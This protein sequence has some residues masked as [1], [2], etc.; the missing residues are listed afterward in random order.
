MDENKASEERQS[1]WKTNIGW[2]GEWEFKSEING[3]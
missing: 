2:Y 1:F 3:M